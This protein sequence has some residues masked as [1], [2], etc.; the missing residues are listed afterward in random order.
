MYLS[1]GCC[2]W[3]LDSND[4]IDS[5]PDWLPQYI[6]D[7]LNVDVLVFNR[8]INVELPDGDPIAVLKPHGGTRK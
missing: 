6:A 7:R 5:L 8:R 3:D 4:Y 2:G 1:F